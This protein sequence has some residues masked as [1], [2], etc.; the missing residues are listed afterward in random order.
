M[1]MIELGIH[2]VSHAS[3]NRIEEPLDINPS[4]ELKDRIQD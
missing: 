3:R 1:S 2:L 4:C